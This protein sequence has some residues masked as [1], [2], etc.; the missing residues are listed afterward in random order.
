MTEATAWRKEGDQVSWQIPGPW[1]QTDINPGGPQ[2]HRSPPVPGG[3][4]RGQGIS[5][6]VAQMC[7]KRVQWVPKPACGHA[8]VP[9]GSRYTQPPVAPQGR[10]RG[11]E[12]GSRGF[13]QHRTAI[14]SHRMLLTG[15]SR[16]TQV[17]RCPEEG[18]PLPSRLPAGLGSASAGP[19]PTDRLSTLGAM[20]RAP[21]RTCRHALG[22]QRKGL[23]ACEDA[24]I[25]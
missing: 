13:P 2:Y 1:L 17:S 14:P 15:P 8:P 18:L 7:R 23:H 6:V 21:C 24:Q 9:E 4:Y 12:E 3:A 16:G 11:G 10:G 19:V 5:G 22:T 20:A 25:H